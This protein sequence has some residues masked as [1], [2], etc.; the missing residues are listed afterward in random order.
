LTAL[1][2]VAS[3]LTNAM[4]NPDAESSATEEPA[5]K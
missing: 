1:E 3:Q 2:R 4:L 5:S